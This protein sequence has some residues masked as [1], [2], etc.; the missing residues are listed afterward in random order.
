MK[1]RLSQIGLNSLSGSAALRPILAV[2]QWFGARQSLNS[3]SGSAALRPAGSATGCGRRTSGGLPEEVRRQ[4]H[5][6]RRG[7]VSAPSQV[8]SGAGDPASEGSAE[9]PAPS[10]PS[11][12]GRRAQGEATIGL[13]RGPAAPRPVA[14]AVHRVPWALFGSTPFG[15]EFSL[16]LLGQFRVCRVLVRHSAV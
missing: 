5:G 6:S 9:F 4:R 7:S 8:P 14:F 3:L 15:F 12:M 1:M 11:E 16:T 10:S 13:G 2:L